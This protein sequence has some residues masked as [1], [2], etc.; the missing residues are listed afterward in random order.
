MS[1]H[2]LAPIPAVAAGR[3][4]GKIH[5]RVDLVAPKIRVHSVKIRLVLDPLPDILALAQ[6]M[7]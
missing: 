4:L 1:L 6:D 2:L 5:Q 7:T 3:C